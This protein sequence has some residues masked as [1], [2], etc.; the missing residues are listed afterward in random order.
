M[1]ACLGPQ[2]RDPVCQFLVARTGSC[3]KVFH[4][5]QKCRI[6]FPVFVLQK[7]FQDFCR[8]QTVL[9][10]LDLPESRVQIDLAEIIAQQKSAEAVDR[11]DLGIVKENFLP[12]KMSVA[13]VFP[14]SF[15]EGGADALPHLGCRCPGKCNHEQTVDIRRILT[16]RDQ[17]DDPL[18]KYCGLAAAGRSRD[19]YI[20]ISGIQ[21]FLLCLRKINTHNIL[22]ML[23]DRTLYSQNI[24]KARTFPQSEI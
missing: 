2:F 17:A 20:V 11:S 12:L 3:A 5:P 4:A 15:G 14:E 18:H 1:A 22:S 19:Q 24:F 10:R 13:R 23:L 6:F 21:H 8:D 7:V 9:R 16:F